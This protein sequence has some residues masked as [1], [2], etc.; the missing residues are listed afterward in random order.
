MVKASLVNDTSGENHTGCNAVID[1][2]IHVAALHGIKITE[3]RRRHEFMDGPRAFSDVDLIIVN[4]E[5]NL[6]HAG[7]NT[8][9]FKHL[10]DSIDRPA[11]LVNTVWDSAQFLTVDMAQQMNEV[12]G[13]CSARESSSFHQLDAVYNGPCYNTP[14]MIFAHNVRRL[15]GHAIEEWAYCAGCGA[16]SA[17]FRNG[18]N[19]LDICGTP[20]LNIHDWC[21]K[22]ARYRGV[23]SGR[24]HGLCMCLMAGIPCIGIRSNSH[25]ND[26]LSTDSDAFLCYGGLIPEAFEDAEA[27]MQDGIEMGLDYAAGAQCAIHEL[28]E[29]IRELA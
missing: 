17:S 12:F 6:H 19:H 14:D 3:T 16:G 10:L 26:A 9:Y 22:A 4:G 23:V 27:N 18:P 11:C 20:P 1:A 28:F 25:K 21:A 5:G 8:S 13:L 15:V 29:N 2:F 24:F 7:R